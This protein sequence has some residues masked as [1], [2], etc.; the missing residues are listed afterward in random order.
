MSIFDRF[1][2]NRIDELK[3]IDMFDASFKKSIFAMYKTL[4]NVDCKEIFIKFNLY[5]DKFTKESKK[6]I[7]AIF[8]TE[9]KNMQMI[10]SIS[11]SDVMSDD[12]NY[13]YEYSNEIKEKIDDLLGVKICE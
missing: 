1:K 7:V 13:K 4:Y 10:E 5:M 11:W 3:V 2:K 9:P 12:F 8:L 6:K